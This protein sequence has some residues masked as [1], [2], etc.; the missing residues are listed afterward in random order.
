M[1]PTWLANLALTAISVSLIGM[2]VQLYRWYRKQRREEMEF[3]LWLPGALMGAGIFTVL[4][5]LFG[6]H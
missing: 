4:L 3:F 6:N 5:V 2:S 1:V